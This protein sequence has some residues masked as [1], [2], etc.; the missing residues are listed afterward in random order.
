[1]AENGSKRKVYVVTTGTPD[2]F[3][4]IGGEM[5]N[6]LT[7][8]GVIIDISDKDSDWAQNIVGQK[9]WTLSAT[10][11]IKKGATEKQ[12]ILFDALVA[13]TEVNLAIGEVVSNAFTDGYKGKAVIESFAESNEK[14]GS[15]TRDISFVGNG[16]LEKIDVA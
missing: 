8:N 4:A 10:F 14:D 5:S 11:N 6:S 7:V 3:T 9:S 15:V 1:M 16:E 13:G 12:Q 2:V